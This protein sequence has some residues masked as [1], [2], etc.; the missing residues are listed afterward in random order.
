[1][2]PALTAARAALGTPF[3]AGADV[4]GAGCDCAGLVAIAARAEGVRPPARAA[5]GEDLLAAARA[6]LTP[7]AHAAPGDVLLLAK[8]PGGPPAH[9]AILDE[10]DRIIH[11]HWSRG[12]VE[13]RL[14]GWFQARVV[15]RFTWPAKADASSNPDEH[16]WRP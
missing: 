12:V 16:A 11:A 3:V 9:A 4:V 10:G 5:F 6:H 14:G 2:R 13:N 8:E 1:M 15:A 7:V